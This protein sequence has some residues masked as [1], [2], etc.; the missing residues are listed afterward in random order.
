MFE[1]VFAAVSKARAAEWTTRAAMSSGREQLLAALPLAVRRGL[2]IAR[3]TVSPH[4]SIYDKAYYAREVEGAAAVAAPV[5]AQSIY[6]WKKPRTIIDVGCGTGALL[7]AFRTLGCDVRGLEYA[8]AGLDYCRKR[9]LNVQKFN[10]EKDTPPD[11]QFDIAVSFEIAEHLAPWCADRYVKLLCILSRFVVMSA[12]T[13]G[14]DGLDHIN[15]QPHSYWI[16]KFETNGY[17]LDSNASQRFLIEWTAARI[18]FWY[19][20]NVMAFS[21]NSLD[22]E[23]TGSKR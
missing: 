12:A 9:G 14:Q 13:P 2:R 7:A 19:S 23:R 8:D 5:M 10:V 4:D 16:K 15:E 18:A 6:E 20:N 21:R 11:Q 3:H 1:L 17:S 22:D